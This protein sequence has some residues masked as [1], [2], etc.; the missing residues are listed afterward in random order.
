MPDVEKGAENTAKTVDST[1]KNM[2]HIR[3]SL[4]FETI[5]NR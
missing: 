2:N 5:G 4:A 1:E 3:I